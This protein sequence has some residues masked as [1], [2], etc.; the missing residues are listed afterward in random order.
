MRSQQPG[1]PGFETFEKRVAA[2]HHLFSPIMNTVQI[3]SLGQKFDVLRI[4]LKN[5]CSSFDAQQLDWLL[6]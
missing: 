6:A 2:D 4:R 3:A 1:L 5:F